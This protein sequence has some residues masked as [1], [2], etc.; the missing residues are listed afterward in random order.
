MKMLYCVYV[1]VHVYDHVNV[2]VN[3]RT[4]YQSTIPNRACAS[5]QGHSLGVVPG[6][7]R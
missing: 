6:R 1:S 7:S 5:R 2:Y 4:L 3:I